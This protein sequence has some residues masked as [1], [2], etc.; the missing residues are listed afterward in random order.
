[1]KIRI[2]REKY[3]IILKI[4]IKKDRDDILT[5]KLCLQR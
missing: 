1:M 4:L 2:R 5:K 3:H